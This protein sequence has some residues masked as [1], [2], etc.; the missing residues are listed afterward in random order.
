LLEKNEFEIP[1]YYRHYQRNEDNFFLVAA[2]CGRGSYTQRPD[3][4]VDPL[5][6][7]LKPVIRRT[8]SGFFYV[9]P[10]ERTCLEV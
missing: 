5:K 8:D 2:P 1:R 3:N 10:A 7:N 6:K 9:R 4:G